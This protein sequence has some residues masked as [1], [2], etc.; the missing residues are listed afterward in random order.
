MEEEEGEPGEEEEVDYEKQEQVAKAQRSKRLKILAVVVAAALAGF[1]VWYLV[2]SNAA[3]TAVFS[4]FSVD[5]RLSVDASAS[6]DP[7]NNIATYTWDFGDGSTGKD[8]TTVHTFA[9]TGN[10]VVTLTVT[11]ARGALDGDQATVAITFAP[12]AAF[13]A[14]HE[15]MDVLFD[16]SSSSPSRTTNSPI[17]SYAWDFGDGQTGTGATPSH[18]YLSEGRYRVNLTVRDQNGLESST[19]R[20]VSPASTTV[21]ILLDEF[22]TGS[23]PFDNYWFLRY[24]SYGDQILRNSPPCTDYYP[25]VLFTDDAPHNP[26]YVYTLYRWDARV[27]NHPEYTVTDPVMLP[28]FNPSVAPAANSYIKLNLS[29]EYMNNSMLDYYANT[30]DYPVNSGFSDGFGYLITGTIQMDLTMARRLFGMRGALGSLTM[31]ISSSG[32][33]KDWDG[34]AWGSMPSL[35]AA[36]AG[37][38]STRW[39]DLAVSS[40]HT[41]YAIATDGSV[42]KLDSGAS[43]WS[44]FIQPPSESWAL[45]NTDVIALAV[46]HEATYYAITQ[47]NPTTPTVAQVYRYTGATAGRWSLIANLSLA[48]TTD[49]GG[50]VDLAQGTGTGTDAFLYALPKNVRLPRDPA[51]YTPFQ[52][53]DATTTKWTQPTDALSSNNQYATATENGATFQLGRYRVAPLAGETQVRS[54]EVGIEG[55]TTSTGDDDVRVEF[56]VNGGASWTQAGVFSPGPT[57][58]TTYYDV[59]GL[60]SWDFTVLNNT[61]FRTR[62]TYVQVGGTASKISV[63]A[64][65][66]RVGFGNATFLRSV[67]GGATWASFGAATPADLSAAN[68]AVAVENPRSFHV[69]LDNG[70]LLDTDLNAASWTWT[71]K[72]PSS[73]SGSVWSDLG[74]DQPGGLLAVAEMGTPV[75]WRYDPAGRTWTNVTAA[76]GLSDVAGITTGEIR[77]WWNSQTAPAAASGPLESRFAAWLEENGNIKHDI[78]NG[79]EWYYQTDITDLAATVASD[80]TVTISVFWDGWGYDVLMARWFYWGSQDYSQAVN[81]PYGTIQPEGWLPMESCWC[82]HAKIEGT[83]RS[84]LDLN[85]T[86]F[87]GY[88]FAAWANWGQDGLPGTND[89]LPAWNFSPFLMD[90]VPR[91]GSVSPGAGGYGNSELR[92]YEG[93]TSIHGAPGSFAYGEPYEYLVPPTR[94]PFKAG[95][96]LTLVMPK[97]DVP[98]YN[99]VTSTWNPTAGVGNYDTF[100]APMTLRLI[101]PTG[102]YYIW[103]PRSKVVSMAGPHDWGTTSMPLEGAPWIEFGPETGG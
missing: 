24:Y 50:I 22:F 87:Q 33:A 102:D 3:P 41:A 75:V 93:L 52:V 76:I 86:A 54:V 32:A 88:S 30:T 27:R 11:D 9:Q 83:I 99:P 10:Y 62:V 58:T 78:Y 45:P 1:G 36:P 63:D 13:V 98:W 81:A 44:L 57:D 26:S 6:T 55:K 19:S 34:S 61:N 12:V 40:D 39:S 20:L 103:D 64:V 70:T 4:H 35:P 7:D 28:V 31:A 97:F 68:R 69:L 46:D 100:D 53:F 23:C 72:S 37:P 21:D 101:R 92:W 80:G 95:S 48:H 91:L 85:F 96:T 56:S 84:S 14:R 94:W 47:G 8:R 17:V 18:T 60:R 90:Y 42:Y 66:I 82:E 16:A 51:R 38:E 71:P 29:M 65:P 15:R 79:F 73:P 2:F 67:D 59:T 77:Q 5:L 89:D 74:W 49:S 43:S 25:W